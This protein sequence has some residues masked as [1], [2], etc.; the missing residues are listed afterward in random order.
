MTRPQIIRAGT[1]LTLHTQILA[2]A[3][4]IACPDTIDLQDQTAPSAQDHTRSPYHQ[5]GL[6]LG[7]AAPHQASE[8][9][10]ARNE[11]AAEETALSHAWNN[12]HNLSEEPPS[13]DD[14]MYMNGHN[15]DGD[16]LLPQNGDMLTNGD[17]HGMDEDGDDGMDEMD[18]LSSSPSISD[19]GYSHLLWPR[20]TSS[21]TP[22]PSPL[23]MPSS[24]ASGP[25]NSPVDSS[26]LSISRRTLRRA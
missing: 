12:N 6:V 4:T 11:R 8:L 20:R 23:G 24:E 2:F 22:V 26:P 25:F 21:L 3:L 14:D 5:A 9:R 18:K 1:V 13:E 10:H 7:P 19:G 16:T 17:D 15:V